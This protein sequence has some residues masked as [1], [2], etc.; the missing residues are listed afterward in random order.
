MQ[1]NITIVLIKQYSL[2]KVMLLS[3]YLQ[4]EGEHGGFLKTHVTG[5][6][7]HGHNLAWAVIDLLRWPSDA[8]P[9]INTL[10][11]ILQ[12]IAEQVYLRMDKTDI[13]SIAGYLSPCYFSVFCNVLN[14][15]VFY[16]FT[17]FLS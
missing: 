1:G 5:V 14:M 8:N 17:P 9:T 10:L 11:F 6:L 2:R 3:S 7:S 16:I 12:D 15:R 13:L 4:M